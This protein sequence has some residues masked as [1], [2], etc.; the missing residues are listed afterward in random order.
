MLYLHVSFARLFT[1]LSFIVIYKLICEM[2]FFLDIY[3]NYMPLLIL[4]MHQHFKWLQQDQTHNHLVR[5]LTVN[6]LVKLAGLS[7]WL[8]G[9]LQTKWLW[10]R[11]LLHSNFR[12]RACFGQGVSWRSANY[13]VWIRSETWTWRDKNIQ[14]SPICFY[15]RSF[16]IWTVNNDFFPCLF[17]YFF[18]DIFFIPVDCVFF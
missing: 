14:S 15:F 8:S 7:K 6:Q 5:K 2:N 17:S 1:I 9:C 18:C 11:I 3:D 16:D 4:C 10:V 12:Y 13:R